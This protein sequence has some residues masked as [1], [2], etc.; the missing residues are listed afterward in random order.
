[1]WPFGGSK[2]KDPIPREWMI[3]NGVDEA[4]SNAFSRTKR[5]L[6]SEVNKLKSQVDIIK[7][8]VA[9][10][11]SDYEIKRMDFEELQS[12][13]KELMGKDSKSS[14]LDRRKTEAE[15]KM[16]QSQLGIITASLVE[17]D[18]NLY[19]VRNTTDILQ[20]IIDGVVTDQSELT[21]KYTPPSRDPLERILEEFEGL[22]DLE[23]PWEDEEPEAPPAE[24]Q[25]EEPE[26]TWE[27]EQSDVLPA[28]DEQE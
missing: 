1:M 11:K 3:T 20:M 18:G 16:L 9:K 13:K 10:H 25:P 6:K 21:R 4:Y 19:T 7:A 8:Q 23:D 22:D 14:L 28:A 12:T 5:D 2:G 15:L 17:S 27:D 26:D 24:E